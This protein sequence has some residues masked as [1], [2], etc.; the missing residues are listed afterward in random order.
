MRFQ[1]R[2]AG[3]GIP[4]IFSRPSKPPG[5]LAT[6]S[7]AASAHGVVAD[8]AGSGLGIGAGCGDTVGWGTG[9]GRGA[10][11]VREATARGAGD[12]DSEE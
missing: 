10:D 5:Q 6:G 4:A 3:S 9:P 8:G 7:Y 11:R 2:A 1:R 12:T